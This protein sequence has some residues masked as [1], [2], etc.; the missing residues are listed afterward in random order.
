MS[1]DEL[2]GQGNEL[3]SSGRFAEAIAKY[4]VALSATAEAVDQAVCLR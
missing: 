3:Y 2:K 1:Y 4:S